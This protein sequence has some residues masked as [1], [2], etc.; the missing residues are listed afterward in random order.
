[1]KS[2]NFCSEHLLTHDTQGTGDDKMKVL[3]H[4]SGL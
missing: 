1:M 2:R 3:K 4:V